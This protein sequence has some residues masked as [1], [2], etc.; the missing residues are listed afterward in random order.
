MQK[1][2]FHLLK[3]FKDAGNTVFLSSH[4]L[5]E[6]G[7]LCDRVAII[8]DGRIVDVIDLKSTIKDFGRII[9]IEGNVPKSFIEE[10]ADKIIL[11]EENRYRFIYKGEMDGLIKS[12]SKYQIKDLSVRKEN[13]EDTFMKYYEEEEG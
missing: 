9:D 3:E 2:L 13:L 5:V 6:V 1:K 8:K 4:N 12:L 11:E 7:N 10:L